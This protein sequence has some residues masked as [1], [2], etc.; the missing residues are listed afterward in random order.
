MLST[1]SFS[2]SPMCSFAQLR[3]C[4]NPR[5]VVLA[6]DGS[7]SV[8]YLSVAVLSDFHRFREVSMEDLKRAFNALGNRRRLKI[9]VSLLE[10]GEATVGEIAQ[11]HRIHIT[12]ASR[13]LTKLESE[14]WVGSRNGA[15]E[16]G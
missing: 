15:E 10:S 7:S 13:H 11:R 12:S 5:P 1:S 3:K 2:R 9:L 16:L 14:I 6:L 4:E 8:C